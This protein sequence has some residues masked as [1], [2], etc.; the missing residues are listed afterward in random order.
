MKS[1]VEK[2]EDLSTAA[3]LGINAA[4]EIMD[5]GGREILMGIAPTHLKS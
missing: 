2:T 1:T 5:N 4:D 3:D